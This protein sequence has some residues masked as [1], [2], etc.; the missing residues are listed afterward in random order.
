MGLQ[1]MIYGI[2]FPENFIKQ[3]PKKALLRSYARLL[4]YSLDYN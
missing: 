2:K 4:K 1:K 3:A